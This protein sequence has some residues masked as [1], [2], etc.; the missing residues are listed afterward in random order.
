MDLVFDRASRMIV[1]PRNGAIVSNLWIEQAQA[2]T[3]VARAKRFGRRRSAQT[4]SSHKMPWRL[5]FWLKGY[6]IE[7]LE[8][9]DRIT[10]D[11]TVMTAAALRGQ[12][13]TRATSKTWALSEVLPVRSVL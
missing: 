1:R 2:R 8:I 13:G 12:S 10:I 6:Q 4:A 9:D 3:R 5:P 7:R 11:A